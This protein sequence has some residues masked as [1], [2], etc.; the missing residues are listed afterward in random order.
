MVQSVVI[1]VQRESRNKC[2]TIPHRPTEQ[3]LEYKIWHHFPHKC[4]AVC[5]V[6][7]WASSTG[8]LLL[9][10]TNQQRLTGLNNKTWHHLPHLS[11]N[12]VRSFLYTLCPSEFYFDP[13]SV[14]RYELCLGNKTK[15]AFNLQL[16]LQPRIQ[17]I[18]PFFFS[19]VHDIKRRV[20]TS[21]SGNKHESLISCP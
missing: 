21:G 6:F 3:G 16:Y 13:G 17:R 19:R 9:A 4:A 18:M 14:A 1:R 11:V 15:V 20:Q 7:E 8:K 12:F 2:S 5:H 10:T